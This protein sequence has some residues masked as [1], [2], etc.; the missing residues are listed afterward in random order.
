MTGPLPVSAF[1]TLALHDPQWGFYSAREPIGTRGAF[2]TAPEISQ[3]FGELLGLW[4]VQVW[5]DQGRPAKPRLVELGPGRGTLMSDALRALRGAPDFLETLEVVLVESSPA[6]EEAQRANLFGAAVPVYWVRQWSEMTRDRPLFLLAN[7]FLD[8][9][10]V[11]QFVMT[12]RGWCERVVVESIDAL[13]FALS[14]VP[15]PLVTPARRGTPA[16]GAI[17]EISAAAE[18][19]VEDTSKAVAAQGGGALFIDYGHAGEGFGDTLQAVTEHRPVDILANPGGADIS[20]HVDFAAVAE[21]ACRGGSRVWGPVAQGQFLHA[22]G[23]DVRASRLAAADPA[24]APDIE[25]AVTR[26]TAPEEMGRLFRVLALTPA[27]A[28]MPPGF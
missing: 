15:V 18:A 6:L 23:I 9:L 24:H 3:I 28:S 4:C 13:G 2:I 19:L 14:P 22:L 20:A 25:A 1:M 16:P 11:R 8:V 17:Y 21:S 26:L 5:R 12:E 27:G 10:P 7:E